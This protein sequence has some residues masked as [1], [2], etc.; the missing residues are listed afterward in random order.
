M[1]ERSQDKEESERN[2]D[3]EQQVTVFNSLN[4]EGKLEE[5]FRQLA[6]VKGKDRSLNLNS[7]GFRTI[8]EYTYSDFSDIDD[9]LDFLIIVF[10]C[11]EWERL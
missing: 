2:K 6:T 8:F 3:I 11:I 5:L 1:T 9:K 7:Y 4:S 10:L